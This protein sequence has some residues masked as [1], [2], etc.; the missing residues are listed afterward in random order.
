MFLDS[1]RSF[2]FLESDFKVTFVLWFD[3]ES[4]SER[5]DGFQMTVDPIQPFN[6]LVVCTVNLF[7]HI[8][9]LLSPDSNPVP[10]QPFFRVCL[11]LVPQNY[12]QIEGRPLKRCTSER[13]TRL[14]RNT[15][16]KRLVLESS[17]VHQSDLS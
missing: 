11:D 10:S 16:K 7:N 3:L 2:R 15:S 9:T 13:N 4:L 12:P 14:L 8:R 6:Y 17:S 1:R 5:S